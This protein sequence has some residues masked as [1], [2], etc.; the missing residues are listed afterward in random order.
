MRSFASGSA[1]ATY[2]DAD[3]EA[4]QKPSGYDRK[5]E[6][7]EGSR[8]MAITDMVLPVQEL[9]RPVLRKFRRK[10]EHGLQKAL[11]QCV[12][13]WNLAYAQGDAKTLLKAVEMQ[14]RLS[15]L[16]SEQIDATHRYGLLVL[17]RFLHSH[18]GTQK[19]KS[20]TLSGVR[21]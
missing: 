17:I 5:R 7:E 8:L 2:T 20:L 6:A 18:G 13:A 15:K 12:V 3:R 16:L 1:G 14:A 4:Y 21:L 19:H 11:E 9:R 10:L